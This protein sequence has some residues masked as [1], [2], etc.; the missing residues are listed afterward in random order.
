MRKPAWKPLAFGFFVACLV[1]AT[2]RAGG[3]FFFFEGRTASML[4]GAF[5][6]A[7]G[8]AVGWAVG[9]FCCGFRG[10]MLSALPGLLLMAAAVSHFGLA[11][12]ALDPRLDKAFGGLALWFYGFWLAGGLI[13]GERNCRL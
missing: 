2:F 13:A 11:F 7:A 1:V 3:P 4:H 6:A 8:I 5:G 12:P 9:R 10:V